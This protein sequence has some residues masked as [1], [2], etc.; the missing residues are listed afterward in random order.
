MSTTQDPPRQG[1]SS[2]FGDATSQLPAVGGGYGRFGR[3]DWQRRLWD[4]LRHEPRRGAVWGL[5]IGLVFGLLAGILVHRGPT[6]YTSQTVMIL[7]DPLGIALSGNEGPVVKL[8]D[9]R[10]KYASLASTEVIAGPVAQALRV[11]VGVV[12]GSTTVS[13][14][15][16]SLLF[17]VDARWSTPGLATELSAAMAQEITHYVQQENAAN[18]IPAEDAFSAVTVS[19][20]TSGA[21]SGPSTSKAVLAGFLV[22]LAGFAV[23]FVGRQ[24]VGG[25]YRR[26]PV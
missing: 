23:G 17:D 13:V 6:T 10:F 7:D 9:L 22:L 21:A 1:A 24:A 3:S 5:V 12:L 14:P 2:L 15:Q 8:A 16:S 20:A 25:W 19:P 4:D 11:P 18:H 26:S